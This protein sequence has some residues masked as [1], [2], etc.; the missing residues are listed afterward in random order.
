MSF[1]FNH[2]ST[3]ISLLGKI[4]FGSLNVLM[5]FTS[6]PN[7]DKLVDTIVGF[8]MMSFIDAYSGYHHTRMHPRDEEKM[9]FITKEWTFC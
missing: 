7:I 8:R 2:H 1:C 3:K 6:L 4:E 5:D 9:A